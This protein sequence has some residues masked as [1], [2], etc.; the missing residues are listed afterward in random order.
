MP[1]AK[2]SYEH[3]KVVS[4]P[5]TDEERISGNVSRE[6]MGIAVSAMHRDGIVLLENAVDVAH[7]D[8]LNVLLLAEAEEMEKLP[9][10]HFNEVCGRPQPARNTAS[11][12]GHAEY[13]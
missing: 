4:V 2:M 5:L 1:S 12:Q 8:K 7:I 10:T 9:T 3:Q 11:F 6:H 13:L